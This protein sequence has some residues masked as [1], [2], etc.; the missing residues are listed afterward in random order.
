M[1]FNKELKS[2]LW[3]EREPINLGRKT[4][5]V[6]VSCEITITLKSIYISIII[7]WRAGRGGGFI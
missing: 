1:D 2:V 3:R 6:S 5:P 7:Y 4:G